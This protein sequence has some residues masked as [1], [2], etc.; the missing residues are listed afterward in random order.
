MKKIISLALTLACLSAM[1]AT[2]FAAPA[3]SDSVNP[4]DQ[5]PE[6]TAIAYRNIEAAETTE[7]YN[8][9]LAARNTIIYGE[10]SWTIDGAVKVFNADGSVEELPEFY[11]LFPSDWEPGRLPQPDYSGNMN[12]PE[13]NSPTLYSGNVYFAKASDDN[14]IYPFAY[15]NLP[16]DGDIGIYLE[17]IPENAEAFTAG[18]Y[19]DD[20]MKGI[21][22]AGSLSEGQGVFLS[23]A[24]SGTR[25]GF[26][27][28]AAGKLDLGYYGYVI[29]DYLD[30]GSFPVDVHLTEEQNIAGKALLSDIMSIFQQALG[31]F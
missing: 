2:S 22:W 26:L 1:A 27:I 16:R 4:A 3:S 17:S 14:E 20:T 8:S 13:R 21:G 23:G 7:E 18:F 10:Q 6:M 15:K 19:N 9:I 5:D 28:G 29:V 25:Y 31:K 12:L 11:D 30:S 24:E